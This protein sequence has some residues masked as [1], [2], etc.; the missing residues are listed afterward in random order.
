M[1]E[2]EYIEGLYDTYKNLLTEEELNA[3]PDI[4]QFMVSDEPVIIERRK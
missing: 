1:K 4:R 3:I 2:R